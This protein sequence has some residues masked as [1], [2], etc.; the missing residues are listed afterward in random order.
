MKINNNLEHELDVF[1]H[2]C[3]RKL[4][5]ISWLDHVTN[6]DMRQRSGPTGA[7][8]NCERMSFENAGSHP[9]NARRKTTTFPRGPKPNKTRQL[10]IYMFI[11]Y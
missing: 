6:D 1:H 4:L 11:F 5:K 3:L 9:K 8:R 7:E 2:K 10:G